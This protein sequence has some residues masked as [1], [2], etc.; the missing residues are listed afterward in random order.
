MSIH[1]QAKNQSLSETQ[2]KEATLMAK[3][4]VPLSVIA[5]VLSLSIPQ[6]EH[7]KNVKNDCEPREIF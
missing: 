1:D 5:K 4:G 2:M 6:I 3:A 7:L